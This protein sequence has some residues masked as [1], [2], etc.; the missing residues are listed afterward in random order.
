MQSTL[1]W[2]CQ[3]IIQYRNYAHYPLDHHSSRHLPMAHHNT[4]A[5]TTKQTLYLHPLHSM[6][7]ISIVR[8][9]SV[10]IALVYARADEELTSIYRM[11]GRR[12]Q[13]SRDRTNVITA[14]ELPRRDWLGN[15]CARCWC[16]VSTTAYNHF[17]VEMPGELTAYR[18]NTNML[19]P[20]KFEERDHDIMRTPCSSVLSRVSMTFNTPPPLAIYI[21]AQHNPR[22]KCVTVMQW[23]MSACVSAAFI[24]IRYKLCMYTRSDE[25]V[26]VCV[27]GYLIVLV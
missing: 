24:S 2:R 14:T 22:I 12:D 23:T 26:C 21:Y 1:F 16:I 18:G 20:P 8:Q 27:S 5:V 4:N 10:L 19:L 9:R 3:L 7:I 6:Y 17:L 13:P 15:M 25:C 11:L